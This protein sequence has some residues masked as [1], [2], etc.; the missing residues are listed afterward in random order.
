MYPCVFK[1]ERGC[2]REGRGLVNPDCWFVAVTEKWIL[3]T[4]F[5]YLGI[6]KVCKYFLSVWKRWCLMISLR[7]RMQWAMQWPS[8]QYQQRPDKHESTRLQINPAE[9]WGT[10]CWG[11][12]P[13]FTSDHC[14]QPCG[15]V[16]WL[17]TLTA[18][19]IA[20]CQISV[21][22]LV[23]VALL[24]DFGFR[25]VS[26]VPDKYISVWLVCSFFFGSCSTL[27]K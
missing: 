12:F 9:R 8:S 20:R 13:A 7:Y 25:E 6:W 10:K 21:K 18:C 1:E 4:V 3:G 23:V 14:A 17:G 19:S 2:L 11:A 5:F 26:E 22:R 27:H 24:G 15:C 16:G